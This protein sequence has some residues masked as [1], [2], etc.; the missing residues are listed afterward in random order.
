MLINNEKIEEAGEALRRLLS[1]DKTASV[2]K[3]QKNFRISNQS[4]MGKMVESLRKVGLPE[5]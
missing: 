5:N 1:V 2:S 3:F 4:L